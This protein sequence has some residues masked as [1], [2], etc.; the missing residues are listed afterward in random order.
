MIS[1]K[2]IRYALAVAKHLHF[3]KAAEECA[4]SQSALSS[5]IQEMERQLGFQVFERDNKKVLITPLGRELLEKAGMVYQQMNDISRMS[6]AIKEPLSTPLS[7]GIIPTIAP[8]L[9]PRILPAISAQYPSLELRVVEDQSHK[10]VEAVTAGEMDTAILALPYDCG[11]LLTFPFWEEDF[12]WVTHKD[13]PDA[14]KQ[15]V[16][17]ADLLD[18]NLMLLAEGHCLKDH[19][20][21]A[22][23]MPSESTY[24]LGGSSLNTLIE[25]VAGKLG[26][27]LVPAMA[28]KQLIYNKPELVCRHLDEPGPHRKLAFIVRPNFPSL[29]NIERLIKLIKSNLEQTGEETSGVA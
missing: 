9:L 4:I 6:D 26:T 22:C 28:L 19:A 14:L 18:S 10:L 15:V 11:S 24:R 25:L 2:Q 5:A 8:F 7:I 20:L 27:T 21:S 16:H 1:L 29:H 12:F 3:N 17:S 13:D 23:G